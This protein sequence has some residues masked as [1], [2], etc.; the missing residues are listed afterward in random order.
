MGGRKGIQRVESASDD[1]EDRD[2][3]AWYEELNR[4]VAVNDA[5]DLVQ[6]E[7]LIQEADEQAKVPSTMER[8]IASFADSDAPCRKLT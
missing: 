4:L 5:S 8:S 2:F 1:D 7:R 6:L 3:D